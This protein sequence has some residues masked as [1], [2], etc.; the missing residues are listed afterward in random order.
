MGSYCN[1]SYAGFSWIPQ[2]AGVVIPVKSKFRGRLAESQR[3]R[4]AFHDPANGRTIGIRFTV[5]G[6]AVITVQCSAYWLSMPFR[7]RRKQYSLPS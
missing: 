5:E 4:S 3:W 1:E 2:A 6:G 7:L